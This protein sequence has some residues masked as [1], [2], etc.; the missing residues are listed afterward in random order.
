MEFTV[1]Y[2]LTWVGPVLAGLAL[3]LMMYGY[4]KTF[5]KRLNND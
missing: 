1:E 3:A 5:G 4:E 2:A